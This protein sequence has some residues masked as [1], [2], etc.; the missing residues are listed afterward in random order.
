MKNRYYTKYKNSQ[1]EDYNKGLFKYGEHVKARYIEQR[2]SS[3]VGNELIEA[4][5][6]ERSIEQSCIGLDRPPQ[7]CEAERNENDAY[8]IQATLRL[9]NY[10]T[11]LSQ[12][13]EV[14]KKLS[15]VMRNGYISKK[16]KS[17]EF[18]KNLKKHSEL[19]TTNYL[20]N[21][22]NSNCICD[23]T[24]SS[25]TGFSIIGISGSGK[26]SAVNNS[27]CYYPQ[28]IEHLGG[29]ED[30]YLFNQVTW[31]KI[32]CAY[33]GGLKGICQKFFGEFDKLLNTNY[34]E[35]YGNKYM[36]VERMIYAMAHI[37]LLHGLGLLVI[38]EI[39]HLSI[40]LKGEAFFN[41]FVTMMN[42]VKVPIVYI[43]TYK[44]YKTILSKDFRQARRATGIG[45]MI[46]DRFIKD[47][48]WDYFIEDLWK[49]QWTKKFS[50]LTQELKDLVYEKSAGITDRV[51]KLFLVSQ[52]EAIMFEKEIVDA[53]IIRAVD[54]NYFK[55][56]S[57]MIDALEKGD[58]KRLM[59]YDDLYSPD[60]G[61]IVESAMQKKT[62]EENVKEFYE[63]EIKKK[64]GKEAELRYEIEFT[65]SKFGCNS[66]NIR[67]A[68]DIVIENNG[69]DKDKQLLLTETYK[70]LT[71]SDGKVVSNNKKNKK[72]KKLKEEE[73]KAFL[74][75]NIED[76]SKVK[77]GE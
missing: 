46:W 6:P 18:I 29:E 8:R 25:S 68:L 47:E 74:Q 65:L 3:F 1:Y 55:L 43:G 64:K 69:I 34:L 22:L 44:A 4:L 23:L 9:L 54:N 51:I 77:Q 35:R 50:P 31:I 45:N 36:S 32:D 40:N 33:N 20:E 2:D 26:S 7:Y 57:D 27:L 5:P 13:L 59:N 10:L 60:I 37:S 41:F 56:T 63:S 48:K 70:I 76:D 75:E 62:K 52:V 30:G 73:K 14:E 28:V 71:N 16:I 42:D 67:K 61:D 49:Y 11:P 19:L 24:A 38:D 21:N 58:T 66:K 72:H 17:P 15:I 39:Q 53:N 12:N